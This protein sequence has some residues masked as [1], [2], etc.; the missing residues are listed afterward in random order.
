MIQSLQEKLDDLDSSILEDDRMVKAVQAW[1]KC[2]GDAGF[3]DLAEQDQVDS[4]LTAKLEAIVGPPDAPDPNYDQA[5]LTALQAEEVSMVAADIKCEK[6]HISSV[7]E[8]VRAE[9]E[10]TF[11]EQ[12]AEPAQPGPAS[13]IEA[14]VEQPAPAGT[15]VSRPVVEL[16]GVSRVFGVEPPVHAL[17]EVDLSIWPG[18]WVA[19]VGPSGSGKSTLLN[20]LGLLDRHTSGIYRLEGVDTAELDDLSRA[21]LRGRRIGFIFQS[22]HLLAHR[23]VIENVMLAELYVG[24]PRKGR[25]D[26]AMSALDRVGMTDRAEFLPTRLSGGQQQRAAIARALMGASEPAAV[27]RADGQPGLAERRQRARAVRA[28]VAGLAHPGGDHP[29]RARGQPRPPA[30]PH[31]RRRP[32]GGRS[33]ASTATGRRIHDRGHRAARRPR[34][35]DRRPTGSRRARS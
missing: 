23:S 24:A 30:G 15:G 10:S 22:F 4:T 14:P 6:D 31:H 19:I 18:E 20:I 29:R 11:R 27:R 1:S 5:A 32:P 34:R 9:Y 28:A 8:K 13:V 25:R 17:R 7:E 26:R 12:N 3:P 2:M 21:G 16:A 35:S 33:R